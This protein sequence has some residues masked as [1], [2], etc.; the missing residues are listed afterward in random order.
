VWTHVG[1]AFV[2]EYA[3]STNLYGLASI[4][5][6]FIEWPSTG[7]EAE[8]IREMRAGDLVIP[9][10]AQS[11]GFA[12]AGDEGLAWQRR[13][14]EALGV[15]PD[16]IEA[17]Y[18][19]F[20]AG[21]LR[22]VPYI[23]TVTGVKHLNPHPIGAPWDRAHVEVAEL[24]YPLNTQEF[25]RLRAVPQ[26]LAAQFK[27]MAPRG[28]HLQE[29]PAGTA[30]AVRSAAS[31]SDREHLLRRY[32]V[33]EATSVESAATELT[34][35]GR[36]P[37]EGDR[38]LIAAPGGLLGVH[39][40][41][42]DRALVSAGTQIPRSPQDL[43]DLFDAAR[44]RMVDSDS[45]AHT[46][47]LAAANELV[48]LIDSPDNVIPIDN[49]Q[50]FHDR[51][52]LLPRRVTQALEIARRPLPAG[53]PPSPEEPEGEPGEDEVEF[54]ELSALM[55]LDIEAVRKALPPDM[56]LADSVL[57][58][59]VTALRSGKHLLLSGP[60]G[61]GKTTLAEALARAVLSDQYNVATATADWTTFDTIGGYMPTE[62]EM[63]SF[64]PGIVLR[65]LQRGRWLIIDEINRADIDKAFGPLF[66]LLAGAGGADGTAARSIVLPFQEE[67][68]NIEVV[69]ADK[70]TGAKSK[71]VLTPGWRLLG[72]LNVRDKA[73]LFQLSFAFLRRFA[74]VDVPL[75]EPVAYRA[76]F[77]ARCSGVPEEAR[78]AIVDAA[79]ALAYGPR[80]LGPAIL[81]DI[82]RFV[83][84]GLTETASGKPNYDDPVDAFLTAVRLYAV[85]QYEGASPSETQDAVAILRAC[86]PDRPEETWSSLIEAFSFVAV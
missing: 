12:L 40:A 53:P 42:T 62:N 84:V 43:R 44:V 47:A 16:A 57:A 72:T 6:G 28:R 52:V 10:F 73:S 17:E 11:P 20:V 8:L 54:D 39:D 25:L 45:F 86:W 5:S 85:P 13:Y 32:S 61:T 3:L 71:F 50:R 36:S 35:A 56:E 77:D 64:E 58:E 7:A 83:T 1:F 48:E 31:T 69:W 79:V 30:E 51:Y 24:E 65:S 14:C 75:P 33:V 4:R 23:L 63:L 22:A 2:T 55:G 41:G 82:A 74:V 49:F 59:A 46:H 15:D 78:A 68:Q 34:A 70:R 21:G 26:E 37:E 38:V 19:D 80:E 76:W 66:T 60:P 67:G 18:H 81:K 27:A 9:K 29:I